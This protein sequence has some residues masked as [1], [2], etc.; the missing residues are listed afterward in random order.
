M[1]WERLHRVSNDGGSPRALNG[2]D[3][4]TN[5]PGSMQSSPLDRMSVWKVVESSTRTFDEAEIR[6]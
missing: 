4:A 3:T 1:G 5:Y 6:P 2:R